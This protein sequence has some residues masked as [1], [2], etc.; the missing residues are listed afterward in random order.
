MIERPHSGP[1]V[2]EPGI[3]T[4]GTPVRPPW[5]ASAVMRRGGF[6]GRGFERPHFGAGNGVVGRQRI[7]PG[8]RR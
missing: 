2:V 4:C 7:V 1:E 6:E 3:E 5:Q 8:W